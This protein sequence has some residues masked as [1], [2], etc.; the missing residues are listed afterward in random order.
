MTRRVPPAASGALK[1]ARANGWSHSAEWARTGGHWAYRVTVSRRATAD[2][3][4]CHAVLVW[5][6]DSSGAYAIGNA[7]VRHRPGGPWQD[8]PTIRS[9]YAIMHSG[10]ATV[11]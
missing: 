9:L 4:Y 1:M 3:P 5:H 10:A 7:V 8:L 2:Q 11:P 6:P